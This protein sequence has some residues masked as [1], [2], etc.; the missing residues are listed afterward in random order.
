MANGIYTQPIPVR[1]INEDIRYLGEVLARNAERKQKY[2][3]AKIKALNDAKA[4]SDKLLFDQF[5]Y[6][7]SKLPKDFRE[8][9]VRFEKNQKEL[10]VNSV[11][12]GDTVGAS[13][14]LTE[15]ANIFSEMEAYREQYDE[16]VQ[17]AKE[18]IA[19]IPLANEGLPT[20]YEYPTDFYNAENIT[21]LSN[22]HQEGDKYELDWS[23]SEG[24]SYKKG[25]GERA[26]I[27]RISELEGLMIPQH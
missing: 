15:T 5:E 17:F 4:K 11:A 13:N 9:W 19:D 12:L 8:S 7:V 24:W 2:S 25:D 10:F 1:D 27:K 14:V 26:Y 18:V 6:S 16:P 23:P 21:N 22:L 3:Q 20:G